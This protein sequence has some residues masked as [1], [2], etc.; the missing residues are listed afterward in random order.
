MRIS[1]WSS[2]VCFSD[3]SPAGELLQTVELPVQRPTMIAFGGPDLKPAFVTS[4]GKNLTDAERA[5]Q[6]NAGGEL[7]FGVK[8]PGL[9]QRDFGASTA[10]RTRVAK[11]KTVS[12]RQERG[13]IH[14]LQKKIHNKS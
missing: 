14:M 1:D 3:L 13:G 4:A 5:K 9:I 7:S 6:T 2:D 12:E 11:G 8:L 10:D